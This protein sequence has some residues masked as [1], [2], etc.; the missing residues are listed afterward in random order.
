MADILARLGTMGARRKMLLAFCIGAFGALGH[1]PWSVWPLT[2]LALAALASLLETTGG[3]KQA[4]WVGW[5]GGT[6]WFALTLNWIVEP[7]LV[8]IARH[9][10]MAPFALVLLAG[11]LALF[12]AA[13]FALA[14]FGGAGRAPLALCVSLPLFELLRA[15]VFTGFPWGMVAYV[16]EGLPPMQLVGLIGSH[17]L[18]VLT[19]LMTAGVYWATSQGRIAAMLFGAAIWAIALGLPYMTKPTTGDE[20]LTEHTLRLIQPNAPQH[21]KWDPAFIPIFWE[22]QLRMTAA[23]GTPDLIIWPETAVPALLDNADGALAAI[24]AAAGDIPV[25]FGIQRQSEAGYHNTLAMIDGTGRVT[26]IYDKHHLVPF[27]EYMPLGDL[28]A[29]VGIHGLAAAN[30]FGFAAGPGPEVLDLGSFGKMLPLICYEAVFPQDLR[31]A[32]DR[33]GWILQITNDAWFGENSGPYQHLVQAQ[34]RAVEQGLPLIRVANTGVSAVIGPDG[35][36]QAFLPLGEEGFLDVRLPAAIPLT[37]Y[38]RSGD[39]PLALLLLGLSAAL[40]LMRIRN[41]D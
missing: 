14:R 7:F 17:G 30:G 12:W 10:W 27:G 35:A 37:L 3:A 18:T 40:L 34:F 19:L 38:A 21:Q 29:R 24:S 33:A 32:P 6:G 5:A 36:I 28:F 39:V 41:V 22:R 8:D 13:G 15:Y 23:E 11:G 20:G 31:V 4:A 25:I 1:A 9:G 26:Q 2:L 16:W